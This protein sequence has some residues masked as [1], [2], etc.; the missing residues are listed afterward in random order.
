MA[1]IPRALILRTAGTNCDGET[2]HA[3]ERAGAVA[4]RVHL[5]ALIDQPTQ[6]EKYQVLV[7]PGGFSYGD[8][9]SA[10]KILAIELKLRLG[11]A[12]RRFVDR[13]GCVLGICNGFQAL[14]KTGLLPGFGEGQS[15]TLTNNDS[16]RFEAR[17]VTLKVCS[18]KSDFMERG[19]T[20]LYMPV[21]HGEGKFVTAAPEVL[22][23]L[24]SGDQIV[25]RYA[26]ADGGAPRYPENPNGSQDDIAGIC[27]PTGRILG[28][29]P[30][31]ER[32]VEPTQHPRWTR[33]GARTAGDGLA[34][35]ES[36]VCR[37]RERLR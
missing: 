10:G 27:D 28:L 37:I 14:V 21:A 9:I 19:D 12:V 17:W 25:F 22:D 11:D 1:V 34:L 16:G 18:A 33:E 3:F 2:V 4:V 8:D 13:G 26:A 30:H 24:R 29:M 31:P 32:H 7:L 20:L 23:R 6:L 15:V 5:Q 35:F 36:V